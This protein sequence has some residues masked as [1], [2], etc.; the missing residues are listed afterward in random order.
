MQVHTRSY[1]I[2]A[3]ALVWGALLLQLYLSI[4]QSIANGG[5]VGHGVW[6]Y[7]AFFT[8]LTNVIM[9]AALTAPLLAPHSRL[10]RFCVQSGTIAGIA[11]NILLVGAAY[12]LLLRN[13][14]D[15]QGLQLLGDILLHDVTPLVFVGYAWLQAGVVAATF[16]ARAVWALWP[17]TYFGYAL[18][19]GAV[20]GFY[21]YPF[22]NVAHLGYIRVLVNALGILAGYFLL[23][24][25]LLLLDRMRHRQSD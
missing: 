22:I 1:A 3:A 24:G 4:R 10:G 5:S 15:P 13:T 9:A 23:A 25:L 2:T 19:R 14:W 21:P 8:I 16:A 12:N 6:M 18:V 17:V 20:W 11:A 7:F